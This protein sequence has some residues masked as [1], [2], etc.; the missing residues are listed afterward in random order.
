MSA[1]ASREAE[2]PA[3]QVG[4]RRY[5]RGRAYVLIVIPIPRQPRSR[6][7]SPPLPSPEFAPAI[8]ET[9]PDD[10][11]QQLKRPPLRRL[12][13]SRKQAPKRRR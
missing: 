8:D 11:P 9:I 4:N 7:R 10:I 5:A 12:Q 2:I 3:S 1:S 6:R 13:Q